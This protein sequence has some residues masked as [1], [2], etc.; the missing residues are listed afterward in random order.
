M[1][2]FSNGTQG[3]QHPSP[4]QP[5]FGT[6]RI[7]YLPYNSEGRSV[8][9]LLMKAWDLRVLFTVGTSITT[10]IPNSIIWNGIHHKT[11]TSGGPTAHGYPDDNYL[12]RVRDELACFCIV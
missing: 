11:S 3:P 5:F 6:Q 8:A 2:S 4:G 12:S 10:Q 7:A 1:Y 9:I